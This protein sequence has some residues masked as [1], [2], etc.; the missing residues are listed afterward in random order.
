MKRVTEETFAVEVFGEC[1]SIRVV[2][3]DKPNGCETILAPNGTTSKADGTIST[4]VELKGRHLMKFPVEQ[5]SGSLEDETT[6][7]QVDSTA[8]VS[9]AVDNGGQAVITER[10]R[11]G[12]SFHESCFSVEH[13]LGC[14]P[15]V[16][17][18]T[19]VGGGPSSWFTS[20]GVE[21][22]A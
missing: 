1:K 21:F 6:D 18:S 7:R 11:S 9:V 16:S 3:G 14:V 13:G 20:V 10:P 22:V 5:C 17:F 15:E 12:A 19:E 8:Q 2:D 4:D